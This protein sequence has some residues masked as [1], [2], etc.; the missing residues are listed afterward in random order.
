MARHGLAVT[1]RHSARRCRSAK[2]GSLSSPSWPGP[3]FAQASRRLLRPPS[4]RLISLFVGNQRVVGFEFL[5]RLRRSRDHAPFGRPVMN[6]NM[7]RREF[8]TVAPAVAGALAQAARGGALIPNPKV[9]SADIQLSEITAYTG[10]DY[11]IRPKRFSEVTLQDAFWKP[12]IATNADV[13]IPFEVQKLTEPGR[14]LS[15]NVLEAAIYSLQ[16]H[17]DARLQRQVETAIQRM[18]DS[19]QPDGGNGFFEVA[20]A[21]YVATGK[22]DLLDNATKSA[23]WL[24]QDFKL[25][26]PPFTGGERDAVNCLQLYRVTHDK[27]HLDLAKHYL[28]IRGLPNSLNR[29]RHNQSYMPVTE[30][31]EAVGHAVNCATLMVSLVDVGVLTGIH[32]YFA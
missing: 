11:P 27:K 3:V 30:Q 13:T 17:P 1:A 9:G 28:D 14:S 2:K 29:S 22:R 21:W 24:D 10:D 20:A 16:T 32:E 12:K 4:R 15:G 8:L 31:S 6:K 7:P 25:H 23:D 19:W 26:D 5:P 18:K